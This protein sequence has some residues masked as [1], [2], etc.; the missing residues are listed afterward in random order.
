M[1]KIGDIHNNH[2]IINKYAVNYKKMR[3]FIQYYE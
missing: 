2:R 3:I 1:K